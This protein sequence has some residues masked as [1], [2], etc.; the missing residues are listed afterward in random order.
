MWDILSGKVVLMIATLLL[1]LAAFFAAMILAFAIRA[2]SFKEAQSA[3]TPLSFVV[4]LPVVF[5]LL[6]GIEL[7]TRTAMIPILNVS[8]ATK[9]VI[10]GTINPVH[11]MICYVT[12]IWSK[13]DVASIDVGPASHQATRMSASCFSSPSG[14]DPINRG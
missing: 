1:P 4:I 5:G 8:L 13:S 2:K 14:T 3:L 12:S 6:P 7:S 10:A 11:L 9:E